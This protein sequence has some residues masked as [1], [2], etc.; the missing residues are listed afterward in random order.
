MQWN[1]LAHCRG[2]EK[3]RQRQENISMSFLTITYYYEVVTTNIGILK[4]QMRNYQINKNINKINDS[5]LLNPK[6]DIIKV[7][8]GI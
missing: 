7:S 4:Y 3:L 8:M 6:L 2:T 5:S 1:T